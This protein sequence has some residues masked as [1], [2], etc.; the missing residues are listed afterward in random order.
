MILKSTRYFIIVSMCW[1]ISCSVRP[2]KL[3][4]QIVSTSIAIPNPLSIPSGFLVG[5][6]EEVLYGIT[7]NTSHH[8]QD[9]GLLRGVSIVKIDQDLTIQTGYEH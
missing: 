7:E 6:L 9:G 3:A 4:V 5:L 2:M 1:C 8:W